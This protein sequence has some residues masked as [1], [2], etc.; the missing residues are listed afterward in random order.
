MLKKILSISGKPGLFKLISHGKNMIIVESF[1]DKKRIPSYSYDKVVSLGDI[2]IFTEDEEVP[3]IEVFDKIKMKENGEVASIDP[4]ANSTLLQAYF[5]E[6]LHDFDRERVFP[7]DIKKIIT[8]YNLLI[9][10]GI[11][12]FKEEESEIEA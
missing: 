9:N 10:N 8:W 5:A 7:S 12:D 6:V 3:L 11:S 1:I 2:A 4:K